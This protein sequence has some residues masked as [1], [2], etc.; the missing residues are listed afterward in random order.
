MSKPTPITDSYL[1][2][3]ALANFKD[4]R[5]D[6]FEPQSYEPRE[7]VIDD[8]TYL[9]LTDTEADERVLERIK[10][11]VWAFKAEFILDQCDLPGELA[12]A[13]T[14]FQSDKG[15]DANG[16]L[17]KLVEKCCEGGIEAFTKAAVAAD[18]RGHFLSCYDGEQNESES[19]YIYRTN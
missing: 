15:E 13:I 18:G 10:D 16:A 3:L 8:E 19:Y 5:E 4:R 12:P 7:F 11:E 2:L 17:L 1:R 14:A 9:V 6:E